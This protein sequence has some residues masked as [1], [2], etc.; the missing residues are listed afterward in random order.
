MLAGYA[1][2]PNAHWAVVALESRSQAVAS[3]APLMVQML[4]GML[5]AGIAGFGLILACTALIARPAATIR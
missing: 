1:E 5:P 2:V 4:I 3:L